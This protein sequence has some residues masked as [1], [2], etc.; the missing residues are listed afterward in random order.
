MA[1]PNY[2]TIM[3]PL[4]KMARDGKEHRFRDAA[5]NLADEFSLSA[6]ERKELLPSGQ[7]PVFPNRVGWA[8]LYLVKAG[9]L[10]GTRRGFFQITEQGQKALSKN[11]LKIDKDFL[12]QFPDF[13]EVVK[14]KKEK[15]KISKVVTPPDEVTPE[16]G[17][18]AAFQ[19]LKESLALEILKNAK[20]CSPAFFERLVVDLLI[21]MGYGGS[22]K[23]AGEAIGQAGDGGIDG[24]IKEDQLGLDIIYIQAKRWE[25]TVG[26]PEIQNVAGALQGQKARKG[27]FITTASFSKD[28]LD[29]VKHIATKIILIDGERLAE[30][31]IDHGVGVSPVATYEVKKMDLDYFAEE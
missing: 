4:L 28:A 12:M 27:I 3:L 8:R 22:R 25:G 24:I 15:A 10:K 23:E 18:E 29:Y 20:E 31:M 26:R 16:E 7:Q 19:E 2:Q 21:K 6:E 30:L 1:I 11:P 5:D 9:L 13:V 14:A 17:L